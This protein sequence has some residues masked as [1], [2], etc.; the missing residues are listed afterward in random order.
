[1]VSLRLLTQQSIRFEK[2]L[3]FVLLS[4]LGVF[5]L[6]IL[7]QPDFLLVDSHRHQLTV[8]F[9]DIPHSFSVLY[10]LIYTVFLL[11][12]LRS[13]R[14]NWT[15][16]L[17]SACWVVMLALFGSAVI[18]HLLGF[19]RRPG[20][21]GADVS[22]PVYCLLIAC[23]AW[24]QLRG[25]HRY[26]SR[27]SP[28]RSAF[29]ACMGVSLI[30]YTVISTS[31]ALDRKLF[32]K[33]S[34]LMLSDMKREITAEL[35]D[36]VRLLGL[37]RSGMLVSDADAD[38]NTFG[39]DFEMLDERLKV[40]QG[41]FIYSRSEA[42]VR[43]WGDPKRIEELHRVFPHY[44]RL[45]T[46]QRVDAP[47]HIYLASEENHLSGL[48]AFPL[49]P[50]G[51]DEGRMQ[52]IFFVR[53]S[54]AAYLQKLAFSNVK[55]ERMLMT[56]NGHQI[57]ENFELPQDLYQEWGQE[58]KFQ[59]YGMDFVL[60]IIPDPQLFLQL[61]VVKHRLLWL[62]T[63]FAVLMTWWIV[64]KNTRFKQLVQETLQLNCQL[65]EEIQVRLEAEEGLKKANQEL[66][67]SN[68]DLQEFA[69][70]ASHDLQEPLRIIKAFSQRIHA[71]YRT[72]LDEKGEDYLNR[73]CRAVDRMGTLIDELLNY[74]RV[75]TRAQP[76]KAIDLNALLLEVQETFVDR[77]EVTHGC[78]ILP[79]R[80][81]TILADEV[82]MR[83][84]FQNL[85]SNALKFTHSDVPPVVHLTFEV[86]GAFLRVY[87][88]DNGIGM[89]PKYQ[90]KIFKVF[91]R[92][93]GRSQYPGTGIGLAICK[94]IV[95][96][97]GSEL[98]VQS[99]LG[100]GATFSFCLPL[101]DDFICTDLP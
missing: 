10:F 67:R 26:I 61:Q 71:G 58:L 84:L 12:I 98:S 44:E 78:I 57:R 91:Q 45:I 96:R 99:A 7:L 92:L 2:A 27:I 39:M 89:D 33:D 55:N 8:L 64:Y 36:V 52:Q 23:N 76:F 49:Q 65:Q 34:Q 87:I 82:Q 22:D 53:I 13:K 4:G 86:A 50:Q 66:E 41:F 51:A 5:E 79:D 46:E 77:L 20:L 30:A 35:D 80:I 16:L 97:H 48:I 54:F 32:E 72:A 37:F 29:L 63:A 85:F 21:L 100:E 60:R 95:E 59:N 18:A 73:M 56:I 3:C 19:E 74:A 17:G 70:V 42:G 43:L 1:M 83:Q 24:L 11:S 93:H 101:A 69:Q 94:R 62:T 9:Q 88:K 68:R 31:L 40:V 15:Y 6:L 75:E 90:H 25:E 81:P 47:I 14:S 38:G 28:T